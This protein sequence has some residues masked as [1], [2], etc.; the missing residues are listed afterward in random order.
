MLF[1]SWEVSG[2]GYN[3]IDELGE[4]EWGGHDIKR[5]LDE[6]NRLI[7]RKYSKGQYVSS[8]KKMINY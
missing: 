7:E 6:N 5:I 1:R 8:F 2:I 3:T 4:S